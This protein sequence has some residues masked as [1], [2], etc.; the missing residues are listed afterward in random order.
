[1]TITCQEVLVCQDNIWSL[2]SNIS[3]V[4]SCNLHSQRNTSSNSMEKSKYKFNLKLNSYS[5]GYYFEITYI[6]LESRTIE[7]FRK[8]LK[9]NFS[10][11]FIIRYINNIRKLDKIVNNCWFS[12]PVFITCQRL[13]LYGVK[14]AVHIIKDSPPSQSS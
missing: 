9:Y 7:I 1:M 5:T 3:F 2:V 8:H 11:V 4:S 10:C 12:I 6:F 13:Q 14:I